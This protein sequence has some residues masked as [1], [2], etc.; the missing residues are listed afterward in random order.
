MLN[1]YLIKN[2]KLYWEDRGE[3]RDGVRMKF[4]FIIRES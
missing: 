4:L 2:Y 1:I 3:E